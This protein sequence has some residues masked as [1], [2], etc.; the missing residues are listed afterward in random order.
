MAS[1]AVLA[2]A[3]PRSSATTAAVSSAMEIEERMQV[4]APNGYWAFMLRESLFK[5]TLLS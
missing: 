3:I 2:V 5:K 4:C 1:K